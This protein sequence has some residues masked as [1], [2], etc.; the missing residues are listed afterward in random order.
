MSIRGEWL[1]DGSVSPSDTFYVVVE[2]RSEKIST[3]CATNWRFL[4]SDSPQVHTNVIPI[5]G[6]MKRWRL[7][8]FVRMGRSSLRLNRIQKNLTL[9]SCRVQYSYNGS[10]RKLGSGD[11][12]STI[13]EDR[14][15]RRLWENQTSVS[16]D[17]LLPFRWHSGQ[18]IHLTRR[19]LIDFESS[20][21]LICSSSGTRRFRYW[22][23]SV[24]RRIRVD[25]LFDPS[26][27]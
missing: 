24:V 18:K 12:W 3:T 17:V 13:K 9:V 7:V 23:L 15:R 27:T 26:G 21:Y 4:T 11:T 22:D 19:I 5:C 2:R 1:D 20:Q 14:L 10:W 8:S 25:K 16:N 6:G